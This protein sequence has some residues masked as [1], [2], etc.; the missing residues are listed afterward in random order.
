MKLF[1]SVN[2]VPDVNE[3]VKEALHLKQ[4]PYAYKDLGENRTMALI[5]LNPSL[6]TRMSTQ[7]AALNLGMNAVF[8]QGLPQSAFNFGENAA[9]FGA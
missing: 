7:K 4:Y 6:R 5:F 8:F 3:L 2:D 9:A 1:S